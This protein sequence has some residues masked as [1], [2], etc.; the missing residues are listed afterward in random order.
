MT[1]VLVVQ[2]ASDHVV[3]VIA[4]GG[5]SPCLTDANGSNCVPRKG[6]GQPCATRS[7]TPVDCQ[8]G[9]MCSGIINLT[10]DKLP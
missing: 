4:S 2:M 1:V 7:K 9:L 6:V 8:E 5:R 10:C 3:H